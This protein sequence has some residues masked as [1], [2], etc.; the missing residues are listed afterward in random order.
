MRYTA[1]DKKDNVE[2]F[3]NI[4]ELSRFLQVDNR[5]SRNAINSIRRVKG[6][7]L[8]ELDKPYLMETPKK[9]EIITV[10][11]IKCKVI[12]IYQNTFSVDTG[13]ENRL[14]SLKDMK[15]IGPNPIRPDR[16]SKLQERFWF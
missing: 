11:N 7:R 9:C 2:Y 16:T 1:T 12:N 15:F 6:Y 14:V 3:R 8:R 10:Q 13:V 4:I 5:E